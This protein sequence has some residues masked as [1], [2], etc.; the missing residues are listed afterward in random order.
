[1]GPV[2][3]KGVINSAET[4]KVNVQALD[5]SYRGFKFNDVDF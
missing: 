1:M 2:V 3:W 5:V 4:G